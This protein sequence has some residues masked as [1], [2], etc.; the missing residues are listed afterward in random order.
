VKPRPVVTLD[1]FGTVLTDADL[2]ALC[3]Y[4]PSWPR[5]ERDRAKALRLQPNL[6]TPMP[7]FRQPRY[8]RDVVARWLATGSCARQPMRRVS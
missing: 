7:Q 4:A 3:G 5:R 8:H 1:Q 6:P 2:A